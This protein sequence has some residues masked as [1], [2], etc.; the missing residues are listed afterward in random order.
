[1][2]EIATNQVFYMIQGTMGEPLQCAPSAR[3]LRTTF[4]LH[5]PPE[6]GCHHPHQQGCREGLPEMVGVN[7]DWG[8]QRRWS[9]WGIDD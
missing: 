3:A 8:Y 7:R 9:P 1:M 6:E 2:A 4:R 5:C